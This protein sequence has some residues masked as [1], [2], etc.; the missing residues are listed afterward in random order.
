MVTKNHSFTQSLITPMIMRSSQIHQLRSKMMKKSWLM[1]KIFYQN[2]RRVSKKMAPNQIRLLLRLH[3]VLLNLRQWI[4]L[5]I[6]I[7]PALSSWI[8]LSSFFWQQLLAQQD[9][10]AKINSNLIKRLC[11]LLFEIIGETYHSQCNMNNCSIG[12]QK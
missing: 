6:S 1:W 10:R 4:L 3:R 9:L 11:H 5:E 2:W 7:H 12:W 8:K